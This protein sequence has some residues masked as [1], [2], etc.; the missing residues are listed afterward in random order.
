MARNQLNLLF[1]VLH[2][3]YGPQHWW[4]AKTQVEVCIGAILAQNTSWKNVEKAIARMRKKG[5]LDCKAIMEADGKTIEDAVRSSGFYRQ[6]AKRLKSFCT[7]TCFGAIRQM[8]V[9][10]ARSYLL[11]IKGIGKETA[12]SILLYAFNKPVFVVDAYTKRIYGRVFE[13]KW[14]GTSLGYED[15]R[16]MFESSLCGN[17][18]KLNEMHALLVEHAKLFCTK[19]NPNCTYCP[20]LKLCKFGRRSAAKK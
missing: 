15:L 1:N 16:S 11:S 5:L 6:K 20:A 19:R 18:K 3:E 7:H 10:D 17:I 8:S 12:D 2:S 13:G 4:P 9:A 14:G